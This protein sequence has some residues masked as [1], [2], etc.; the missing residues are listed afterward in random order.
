MRHYSCKDRWRGIESGGRGKKKPDIEK[1]PEQSTS[2][3][4]GIHWNNEE[5]WAGKSRNAPPGEEKRLDG[6][7]A[8]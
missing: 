3:K 8:A 7:S 1:K 4:R 5:D 2:V 6:E